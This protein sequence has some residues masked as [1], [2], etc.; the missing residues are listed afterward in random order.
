VYIV[1]YNEFYRFII[2]T[3]ITYIFG[4][5]IYYGKMRRETKNEIV[6]TVFVSLLIDGAAVHSY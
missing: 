6:I 4:N 5:I 1:F 2:L 3:K